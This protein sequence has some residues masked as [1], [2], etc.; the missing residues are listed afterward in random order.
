MT[1]AL[2]Q[3]HGP[4]SG[5]GQR[6]STVA[7]I[8][9]PLDGSRA[10][11]RVLPIAR[12]L[13]QLY[14]ATPH[15]LYVGG[16]MRDAKQILRFLRLTTEDISGAVLDVRSGNVAEA[17]SRMAR[18][19]P[20]SLVLICANA[21]NPG[22]E[23]FGEVA[24]AVL[25]SAPARIMLAAADNCEQGWQL[26]RV[27]L[28]HDGTPNSDNATAPAAE[29]AQRASAEVVALH[30]AARKA[31]SPEEPGSMT[32]PR[33]LDQPQHEWPAWTQ[34]FMDR[35]LALGAPPSAVH[36]DLVVAGGQ[37][38]S[39]IADLARRRDADLVV[40]AWDGKW[41]STRHA[42]TRAVIRACGCPVLLV[43]SALEAQRGA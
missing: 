33:Y 20:N 15:L 9:I 38:G 36:F 26:Q 27:L 16:E 8:V 21:A 1:A 23:S 39:E 35:M 11:R 25:D 3:W 34:E 10:S 19:L 41:N 6:L 2:S 29:L 7:N 37:P 18:E 28:A 43:C 13:A 40:M 14:N 17:I 12:R 24:E 5:L 4:A 22:S 32:A 30:V 42:A 31:P